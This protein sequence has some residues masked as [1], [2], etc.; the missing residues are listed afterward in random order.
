MVLLMTCPFS[1]LL[2]FT[3]GVLGVGKSQDWKDSERNF[4]VRAK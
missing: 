2:G 1:S 4:K 3:P